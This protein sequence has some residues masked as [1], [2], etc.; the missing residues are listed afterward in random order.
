MNTKNCPICK[1]ESSFY[2]SKDRAN[3]FKCNACGTI[4]Q[5]PL[6]TLQE[7]MDYANAEYDDGLYKEYLQANDLKYETFEY[8]LNKVLEAFKK[9]DHSKASPTILDVGCSNG[10]FIEVANRNGIDAWGLELAENAIAAAAPATRARIYHGDAN[11]IESVG[12]K[13]FDIV[14]AFDL[15]EHLFDPFSFLTNLHKIIT[16]NGLIVVT[17]PDTSSLPRML[18]GKNWPMLQPFQHTILLSRKS[19]ILLLQKTNYKNVTANGTKKV[20]T[21][22]YLF[23][24]LRGPNPKIYQTYRRFNKILPRFI[25]ENKIQVNIGEMIISATPI[26]WS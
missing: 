20:F 7:M 11:N 26:P 4:F 13:K 1:Y 16:E 22:D 3:Y 23:N 19:S 15:I 12:K 17:T 21:A 6:P 9:Q 14:T 25:R 24:Q 10:R 8:R 5:N 18:M 2:C